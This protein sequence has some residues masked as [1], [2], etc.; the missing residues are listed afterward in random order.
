MF[1][2]A[3]S[4]AALFSAAVVA[5]A[6]SVLFDFDNVAAHTPLPIDVTVSG[7]TAHLSYQFYGY[8]VQRAD[9]M[10][11]TPNG[12]SGNCIYPNTVY[13]DDLYIA[14]SQS[15]TEF[16]MLYSPQELACSSSA[17]M[18]VSAYMDATFVG[19]ATTVAPGPGTWPTGQLAFN[20][21]TPFNRVVVHYESPPPTGGDYGVIFLSD[22]MAVTPADGTSTETLAPTKQTVNLGQVDGGGLSRLAVQDGQAETLCKY[23]VPSMTSPF[24]R[25]TLDY[26]T[27]KPTPRRIEFFTTSRMANPGLFKIRLLMLNNGWGGYDE[28]LPPTALGEEWKFGIGRPT[29]LP[30]AYIGANG[31]VQGWIEVFRAG[32]S[33]TAKPCIDIDLAVMKVSG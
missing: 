28:V 21:A 33:S 16:S 18:R 23:L 6:Q 15:L 22:A 13:R 14:F 1:N 9:T 10:G 31:K 12:F 2:R 17:K 27:T 4:I 8:S 7:I 29:D 11:F 26:T 20:S 3:L 30:S 19:T 5:R 25:L 32:P 24:V